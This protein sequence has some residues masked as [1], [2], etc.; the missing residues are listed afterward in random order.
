MLEIRMT[1]FDQG[2]RKTM[3][4]YWVDRYRDLHR[5]TI[6]NNDTRGIKTGGPAW[7]CLIDAYQLRRI[8]ARVGQR[9]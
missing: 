1:E 7:F 5:T 9:L 2:R 4:I 3:E 8:M 6:M